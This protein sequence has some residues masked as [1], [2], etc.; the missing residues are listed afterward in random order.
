MSDE[1]KIVTR[2]A[3]I[4][5]AAMAAAASAL[6]GCQP[7]PT[8]TPV[9]PTKAPAATAV[10]A[11][12]A[13][14]ATAVPATK[15]PAATTG[16]AATPVGDKWAIY[17]DDDPRHWIV[18]KKI[19]PPKVYNNLVFTTN[20]MT[21][22]NVYKEGE[23]V[24][25][26]CQTRWLK[27]TMGVSMKSVWSGPQMAQYWPTALASG[28]L[29]EVITNVPQAV[30]LQLLEAGVLADIKDIWER[31]ASPLTKKKK[32]W[33]DAIWN[34]VLMDKGKM[35][36]IQASGGAIHNG[37][38][39]LWVRQDWLDQVKMKVPDTLD[40]MYEVGMAFVKAGLSKMGMWVGNRHYGSDG[41]SPVFGAFGMVPR[42]WRRGSDGKLKYSST[43]PLIKEGLA[44][45]AK[46]YKDGMIDKEFLASND[47]GKYV[48]GNLAGMC[49][50][51]WWGPA[52]P[53]GTSM[54][55]DPKAQWQWAMIP[56]GPTG[57][58]GRWGETYINL[59]TCF[60]KGTDPLKIE[61]F[62]NMLNWWYEIEEN[63][64][65]GNSANV[66]L[67]KD[68]DF[69]LKDGKA[70][71]S[72]WN[73]RR[74]NCG[75]F[76][77]EANRYPEFDLT[78]HRKLEELTKLD[79]KTLSPIQAWQTSDPKALMQAQSIKVAFEA[80]KYGIVNEMY[81]PTPTA[82]TEIEAALF[83][84]EDETFA[85]IITGKAPLS[86]FDQFAQD[87]VKQGGDKLTA[88]INAEDAKHK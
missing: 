34:Q 36:G 80:A 67:F 68:Y 21:S 73:T 18:S 75:G 86:A 77:F 49:F 14:A 6:A 62:I 84:L 47:V 44:V 11:T 64:E 43:D 55:N 2:R 51:P 4:K 72:K 12:S 7:Q 8:A 74:Y 3:F 27:K 81:W 69:E 37:S 29:P 56:A 53:L 31:T 76:A 87:W 1:R 9:P 85:N 48:G 40:Q 52:F 28:D 17:P 78:A 16:P 35:Y 25:D 45:L 26:N 19:D 33:P 5:Y 10:P 24:D 59:A 39:I 70:V 71:A 13:P 22:G 41:T 23:S 58:R 60:K 66:I 88:A 46:W 65:S 20:T 30:Y 42:V 32:Q 79:P 50:H 57:K 83:K 82:V 61:A 38:D 54:R 15:A 63:N